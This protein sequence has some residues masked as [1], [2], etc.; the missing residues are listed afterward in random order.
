MKKIHVLSIIAAIIFAS[1]CSKDSGYGGVG[2]D[3]NTDYSSGKGGS[4]ARFCVAG[5]YLFTVDHS[6]LK[7]FDISTPETPKFL[8][9]RT[10][11][12]GFGIETIFPVDTLLFIGSQ[13]GM[14]IFHVSNNGMMQHL[15]TT[16]HIR[17]CDPVVAQGNYAY[18]TLNSNNIQCGRTSNIL[19]IY[20]ITDLKSPVHIRDI[21]GFSSPRGLGIDGDRLFVCD[22]GLKIYDIS[23]RIS[24]VLKEDLYSAHIYDVTEP[25]D[26]IPLNGL[27]ILVA[28]SGI[29]QLDY[30]GESLK[31]LS[32]IT[33][34]R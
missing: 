22:N 34:N 14:L 11:M 15:S 32:T 30:S 29:Y 5:D 12:L 27:L 4:M 3:H 25:Y 10:Q 24:P 23:D 1:S 31:L 21:Q 28:S 19:Q 8:S 20:D 17:S 16:S 6:T 9:G 26:V 13:D 18:L 7:S 33:V 2:G